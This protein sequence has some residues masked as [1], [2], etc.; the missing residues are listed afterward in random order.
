MYVFGNL[1]KIV[2]HR[3][4]VGLVTLLLVKKYRLERT[5]EQDLGLL[6]RT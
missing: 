1:L 3:T 5:N 6:L 4:F 2:H